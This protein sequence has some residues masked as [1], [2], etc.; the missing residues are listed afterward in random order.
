[1]AR[2]DSDLADLKAAKSLAEQDQ[3]KLSDVRADATAH[4][5]QGVAF[6]R[7]IQ[8]T[9]AQERMLDEKMHKLQK[10]DEKRRKNNERLRHTL[11]KV[12]EPKI[13]AAEKRLTTKTELFE[14]VAKQH[15]IWKEREQE[16]R[17]SALARLE[18]RKEAEETLK[19]SNEALAEAQREQQAADDRFQKTKQTAGESVEQYR[20]VETRFQAVDSRINELGPEVEREKKGLA[21]LHNVLEKENKKMETAEER[22]KQQLERM[23]SNVEKQHEEK[24]KELLLLNQKYREWQNE[25]QERASVIAQRSEAY[26][27]AVDAYQEKRSDVYNKAESNAAKRA[28]Q[29]SD[30]GWDDWAWGGDI[31]DPQSEEVHISE[32]VPAVQDSDAPRQV[33][34]APAPAPGMP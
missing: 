19:A 26:S 6:K 20:Y 8:Q 16:Y 17:K 7:K 14:K 31:A 11:Q 10:E 32:D 28:N 4:M 34:L 9:M 15:E 27:N 23:E 25:E 18:E 30:W 2:M 12:M 22:Q 21:K 29:D 1:M 24:D 13:Q 5:N 3:A 33:A